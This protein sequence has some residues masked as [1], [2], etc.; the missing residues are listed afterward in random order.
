MKNLRT[1]YLT[2]RHISLFLIIIINKITNMKHLFTFVFLT[3]GL[4]L[5]AQ[6]LIKQTRDIWIGNTW[7]K[8]GQKMIQ[9]D[10]N[11]LPLSELNSNW[12]KDASK[13]INS[14][15]I[16][17][18]YNANGNE[19]EKTT[20][21]WDP[22]IGVW[23]NDTRVNNTYNSANQNIN[24]TTYEWK[25]NNWLF[26]HKIDYEYNSSNLLTNYTKTYWN[27]ATANWVNESREIN[28]Y[29]SE[30][31]L[32]SKE[33]ALW[34]LT[35]NQ[36]NNINR[37]E[38][39]YNNEISTTI[40]KIWDQNLS[41][42]ANAF[43]LESKYNSANQLTESI[44][45]SWDQSTS[46][47][48]NNIKVELSYNENAIQEGTNYYQWDVNE[49]LWKPSSKDIFTLNS[50]SLIATKTNQTFN[51]ST[52]IW[53]NSN[54]FTYEYDMATGLLNSTNPT[55][56]L[57][58]FPNPV[59][60]KLQLSGFE[61]E[62]SNYEILGMDGKSILS[63]ELSQNQ[64]EI[65]LSMMVSGIYIIKVTNAEGVYLGKIIKE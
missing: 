19:I 45:K 35:D 57:T 64:K 54:R 26:S 9:Y 32:I 7:Q 33:F 10:N 27:A 41:S 43:S 52:L 15:I 14:T 61:S 58:L 13:W 40:R 62:Y 50:E 6:N 4:W 60:E 11:N 25:D 37:E 36:W 1:N 48:I 24:L 53:G 65:N 8:A 47:F 16:S 28:E 21:K 42:W 2:I 39:S 23:V 38:Y 55:K 44:S 31:K 29:N 49:Q 20:K 51:P 17:F 5:N 30:G 12:D 59:I 22:S 34:G 63:G 46:K 18:S 56:K 3:L